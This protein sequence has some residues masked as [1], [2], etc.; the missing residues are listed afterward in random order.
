MKTQWEGKRLPLNS[1]LHVK[2]RYSRAT[3]NRLRDMQRYCVPRVIRGWT[4]RKPRRYRGCCGG[5]FT[6]DN[7]EPYI[8]VD[9]GTKAGGEEEGF[10]CCT[11]LDHRG[12]AEV[13]RNSRPRGPP[14]CVSR[15]NVDLRT[16]AVAEPSGHGRGKL[17]GPCT[18]SEGCL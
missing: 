18:S 4:S 10:G 2:R 9:R 6:A 17:P 11:E 1:T 5:D 3:T 14:G 8:P 16:C 7:R 12:C 13:E 15:I